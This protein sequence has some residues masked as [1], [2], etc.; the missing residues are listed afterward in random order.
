MTE[1][2]TRRQ[3]QVLDFISECVGGRGYPPTL[4]EIGAHMGIRSTNGVNDHLKALERKGFLTRDDMKSRALRPVSSSGQA[5]D[6]PLVGKVAAGQ[7]AL[8]VEQAE[9]SV[10]IDRFFIGPSRE[11]FALRVSG[12]S[13]IE[14]GIFDGDFIFVRKQLQ[15]EPGE[16]VVVIVDDEATVKRYYPEGDRIRL[17]PANAAMKPIYVRRQDFRSVNILGVVVGVYRK[18]G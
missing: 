17:Q 8:A 4:R 13:M 1:G 9:E 15:A 11:V 16:I 14:D 3:Q 12:E 18:L 10:K 7:L 2:L 6:V 5:L